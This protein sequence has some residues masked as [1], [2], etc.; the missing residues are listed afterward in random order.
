MSTHLYWRPVRNENRSLGYQLK[1]HLAPKL[2][3]HDGT[4]GSSPTVVGPE[5]VDFLD[6][7]I[8]AT[9]VDDVRKEAERLKALIEK[10]GAV[11]IWLES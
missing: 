7:L 2:W 10:H 9:N 3:G 1:F 4:L 11:E 5:L 8:S 6:G